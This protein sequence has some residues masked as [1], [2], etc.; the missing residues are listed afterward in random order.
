[1]KQSGTLVAAGD[2]LMHVGQVIG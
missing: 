1:M 2:V